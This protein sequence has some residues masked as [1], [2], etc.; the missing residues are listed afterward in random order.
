MIKFHLGEIPTAPDFEPDASWKPLREPGMWGMQLIASFIGL[1]AAAGIAFLWFRLTPLEAFEFEATLTTALGLFGLVALVIVVHE[2]LHGVAHHFSGGDGYSVIGFWPAKVVFYAVYLGP[3]PRNGQLL[4]FALPLTAISLLPLAAAV[5]FQ[6]AIP[7][8]AFIS[9]V[10]V[11]LAAGDIFG[12]IL[13][14]YQVDRHAVVCN[15]GYR[16]YWK[17]IQ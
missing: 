17:V 8:L 9:I 2:L 15:K 6:A 11:A 5:L 10:N 3:M 12:F 1:L 14:T 16:S 7:L 4:S 13:V